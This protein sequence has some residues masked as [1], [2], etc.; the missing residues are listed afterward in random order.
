[1]VCVCVHVYVYVCVSGVYFSFFGSMK[2]VAVFNRKK[3]QFEIRYIEFCLFITSSL[4][5]VSDALVRKD[6]CHCLSSV[7]SH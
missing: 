1:M 3:Y 6:S 7:G 5:C 4:H 2:R